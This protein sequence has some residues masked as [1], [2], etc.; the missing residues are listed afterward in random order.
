LLLKSEYTGGRGMKKVFINRFGQ[1]RSGWK[2]CIVL[3]ASFGFQLLLGMFVGIALTVAAVALGK[4]DLQNSASIVD[5]NNPVTNY[6]F[7]LVGIV[8]MIIA[9]YMIL[10][11]IDKKRFKDAGVVGL[12]KGA[13]HLGFG[14]ILGAVSMT[15]IFAVLLLTK[16]ISLTNSFIQPNFS[17]ST[18]SGLILFILVGFEEEFFSRGYCMMVLQQTGKRWVMVFVSALIFSLLHVGNSNVKIFGLVNIFLV[19][20]LFAYMVIKTNNIWM[21]IGYHITWNYFQGNIFGFPVSGMESNG[22]F[23]I[24]VLKDNLLTGGAFGPE[25][26][27]LT[28]AVILIGL[29][30]VSR[31][32]GKHTYQTLFSQPSERVEV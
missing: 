18:L 17:W 5:A 30:V 6:I 22:L 9:V 27:I 19:G 26:G 15:V 32:N 29:L 12:K 21:A 23:G 2:I 24:E 31:Y 8:T 13:R 25:A 28:T 14:L 11:L 10:R 4:F 7:Q 1:L 3:A 20:V 16:N